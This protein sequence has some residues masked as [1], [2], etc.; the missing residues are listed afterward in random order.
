MECQRT[1]LFQHEKRVRGWRV[2]GLT[3]SRKDDVEET[4]NDC[5]GHGQVWY[6][7]PEVA[8]LLPDADHLDQPDVSLGYRSGGGWHD[9][10][11]PSEGARRHGPHP[12]VG[13]CGV[14]GARTAAHFGV[15]GHGPLGPLG[16]VAKPASLHQR[17]LGLDELGHGQIDRSPFSSVEASF[18]ECVAVLK[19]VVLLSAVVPP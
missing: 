4:E 6:G 16:Q 11:G 14:G 15:E 12:D 1:T 5:D 19:R 7:L 9:G 2:A 13:V 3:G 10:A 18:P 8:V 17:S